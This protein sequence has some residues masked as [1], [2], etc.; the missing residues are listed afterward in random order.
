LPARFVIGYASGT[1][2]G[3]AAQYVVRQ[4]DSHAWVEIYFPGIGWVEFEPTP[5]QPAPARVGRLDVPGVEPEAVRPMTWSGVSEFLVRGLDILWRPVA[6]ALLLWLAWLGLQLLQFG[7]H[8]PAE[9]IAWAYRR[10]RRAAGPVS[11]TPPLSQ[12]A[13]EYADVLSERLAALQ[14]GSRW[15]AWL[16]APV[17]AHLTDL[18]ELYARSLFSPRRPGRAE[19]RSARRLW[20]A[21]WW[22]LLLL[23]AAVLLREKLRGTPLES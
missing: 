11:G 6:V 3:L 22:R 15:H 9:S 4:T 1:Y 20:S 17:R 10:L 18:T 23:D 7:R 8:A 12:T 21:L 14:T 2:D 5:S 16:L 19:A 13:Y